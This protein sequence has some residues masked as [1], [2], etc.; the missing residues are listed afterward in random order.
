MILANAAWAGPGEKTMWD[1]LKKEV[2]SF[3]DPNWADKFHVWRMDWDENAIKLYVDDTL[4][5]TIALEKTI[6]QSGDIKNPMKQPHYLILNLA[7]GGTNGGDPSLTEFPRKYI[8]DY[9]RVYQVPA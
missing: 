4:L 5:N 8:I 2:A 7:V 9:V 6:N 3:E 1:D